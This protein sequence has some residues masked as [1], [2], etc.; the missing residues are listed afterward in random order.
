[1]TPKAPLL[2]KQNRL[3]AKERGRLLWF[4]CICKQRVWWQKSITAAITMAIQSFDIKKD[5]WRCQKLGLGVCA[6]NVDA[7]PID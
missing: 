5:L 7:N 1:L 2:C 3:V 6:Q 4:D